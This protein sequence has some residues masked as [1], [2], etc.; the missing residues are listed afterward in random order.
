MRSPVSG[1]MLATS[2]ADYFT[3][4]SNREQISRLARPA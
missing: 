2:V 3:T 4:E 1:S